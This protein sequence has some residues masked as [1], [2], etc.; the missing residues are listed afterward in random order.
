MNVEK[1][2]IAMHSTLRQ[3]NYAESVYG[4][5]IFSAAEKD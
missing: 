4:V 1:K 5:D 3:Y 2:S